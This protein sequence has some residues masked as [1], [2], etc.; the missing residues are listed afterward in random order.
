MEKDFNTDNFEEL[1][2]ETTDSFRMYP[3]KRV[4]HGIYNDLHPA[5]KW[6]SFAVLLLL[7]TSI[8]YIGITNPDKGGKTLAKISS[9]ANTM[10]SG[11]ALATGINIEAQSS[12]TLTA[13]P[14]RGVADRIT[15]ELP[16]QTQT[17]RSR[18]NLYVAS[19]QNNE[20]KEG[21]KDLSY[22]P[23]LSPIKE[24]VFS[25]SSESE[26][27]DHNLIEPTA[28][29]SSPTQVDRSAF[30]LIST[31]RINNETYT[32]STLSKLSGAAS[33]ITRPTETQSE[34]PIAGATMIA[35]STPG[36][37]MVTTSATARDESG[38]MEDYAFRN[39]RSRDKW[40]G[41]MSYQVYVTPS[42]GYRILSKTHDYSL[43]P[44]NALVANPNAAATTNYTLNH[45]SAINLEI[46]S[47][48]IY[49]AS[50]RLRLKAGAQLNYTNYSVKAQ[51]LNHPTFTSLMLTNSSNNSLVL[52]TRT[53]TIANTSGTTSRFMNNNTYQVS[54]PLGADIKVVGND[55]LKVYLGTTIQPTY[56]LGSHSYLVSA[57]MKN[58]VTEESFVRPFNLNGAIETFVTY[59]MQSGVTL[60]VGPQFRYQFFSTYDEKYNY[61]EKLYN[62]G[63]KIGMTKNF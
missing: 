5:K 20:S 44:T 30:T 61:H 31:D 4:W 39:N 60:N 57:D 28:V 13:I 24:K 2:R 29:L 47:G 55:R 42:L 33:N 22:I 32:S 3:S 23:Q 41:R 25:Q 19:L 51:E 8:M 12:S 36:K 56:I 1:L 34:S 17:I 63:V 59:K 10:P 11:P 43:P 35:A 16:S 58:Y 49:S 26:V 18:S 6:P 38:W 45:A 54:I 14:K 62:I 52:S 53:T 27:V 48:I 46:G 7:V 21:N 37:A 40:K 50:K 15:E 9:D